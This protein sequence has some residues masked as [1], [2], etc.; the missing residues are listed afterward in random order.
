MGLF[1]KKVVIYS[2][3]NGLGKSIDQ[4]ND[5]MF[6]ARALGDGFAVEPEDDVLV[7]PIEGTVTA[8]FPTK[9]A[10]SLK[11]KNGLEVLLH[12]GIDTVELNGLGFDIKV[13][14]GEKINS[15]TILAVVDFAQLRAQGKETDV[16]VIFTNLDQKKVAFKEG[17]AV[18]GQE[19]GVVK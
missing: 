2:P 11:A 19:I 6:A 12:I 15:E 16:M 17:Q 14:E 18:S 13:E 10:I 5:E 8:I 1:N 9:H 4:V 7:S 3:V